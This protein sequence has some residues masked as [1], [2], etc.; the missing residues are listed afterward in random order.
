MIPTMLISPL[1]LGR[2]YTVKCTNEATGSALSQD[3]VAFCE[4]N[5]WQWTSPPGCPSG[6]IGVLKA[7][8]IFNGKKVVF[9]GDSAVRNVYYQF[10]NLVDPEYTS[11]EAFAVKHSDI[12]VQ[13]VFLRNSSFEFY[14]APM[15]SNI[16]DVVR[17]KDLVMR[18]DLIVLGSAVWHALHVHNLNT[19]LKDL[20]ALD[21]VIVGKNATKKATLV[22]LQPTTIIDTKLVTTDKLQHMPEATLVTYREAFLNS[23]V[24]KTV[25]SVVDPTAACTGREATD[26]IHYGREV[27][28]VIAQMAVNS[29]ILRVPALYSQ[30][31]AKKKPTPPKKTGGMSFPKYGAM[32]LTLAAIML[33]SMDSFLGIGFLSLLLFG[34]SCD[35]EAAYGPLHMKIL[36]G[37]NAPV[38]RG[39]P[40]PSSVELESLLGNPKTDE[41]NTKEQ[42][43]D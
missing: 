38:T 24:A 21:A 13:P 32:V 18:A 23:S 27:Y 39:S 11:N 37:A 4:T 17:Q 40:V 15:I 16:T 33:F 2:W 31:S 10:N 30:A 9:L 26:G 34:R 35:W 1:P 3:K 7:R 6:N 12:T 43:K 20:D 19:Y 5:R 22:W 42:Q 28:K 8:T 14:W 29:Y 25:Q 41:E 36:K